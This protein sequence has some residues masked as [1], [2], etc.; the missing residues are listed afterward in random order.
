MLRQLHIRD[1]LCGNVG[2]TFV[3]DWGPVEKHSAE[4]GLNLEGFLVMPIADRLHR[5]KLRSP[6]LFWYAPLMPASFVVTVTCRRA[7]DFMD[8][9]HG[10]PGYRAFGSDLVPPIAR[11]FL[12]WTGRDVIRTHPR[13]AGGNE[14]PYLVD[15]FAN[16]FG[17]TSGEVSKEWYES[18]RQNPADH[19]EYA[20]VPQVPD[21]FRVWKNRRVKLFHAVC[22]IPS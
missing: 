21:E 10:L 8:P 11:P 4:R 2:D 19:F 16:G 18:V 22:I 15:D 1:L 12:Y 3:Y 6:V 5:K 17:L 13:L 7:V 9:L 20:A 14:S